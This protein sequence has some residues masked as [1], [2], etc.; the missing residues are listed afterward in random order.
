M[1]DKTH[2]E[3]AIQRALAVTSP[4]MHGPDVAALQKAVNGLLKRFKLSGHL[5]EDGQFGQRTAELSDKAAYVLGLEAAGDS[6]H[7]ISRIVTQPEQKA[8]RDPDS[9]TDAQKERAKR[10]LSDAQQHENDAW[11]VRAHILSYCQWGV[12]NTAAIHYS[13]TRPYPTNPR[14]LPMYTDCSGWATLAYKDAKA[15]DPNGRGFDGFG[16]TGT[17]LQHCTHI[18]KAEALPGDLIVYGSYPGMHVVVLKDQGSVSDPLTISH[19]QEAGPL[20]VRH[21]VEVQAH[22]NAPVSFLRAL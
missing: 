5:Q 16:F 12:T 1:P 9:R 17:L 2:D 18:A 3:R 10:R 19:G 7:S 11:D 13:Q 21:S 6:P 15:P 22:G 14:G 4:L 20:L 8:I